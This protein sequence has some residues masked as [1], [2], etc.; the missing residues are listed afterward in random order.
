MGIGHS[1]NRRRESEGDT[2]SDRSRSNS[3]SPLPPSPYPVPPYDC[4][5]SFVANENEIPYEHRV[6]PGGHIM[7]IIDPRSPNVEISRTPIVLDEDKP[8]GEK[9]GFKLFLPKSK[10]DGENVTPKTGKGFLGGFDP[11]SPT[12]EIRRTPIAFDGKSNDKETPCPPA[13]VSSLLCQPKRLLV[14]SDQIMNRNS[15]NRS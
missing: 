8:S 6:T 5:R 2:E 4:D 10:N 3:S 7:A 11:R 13:R 9:P 15:G 1:L 14:D 12:E